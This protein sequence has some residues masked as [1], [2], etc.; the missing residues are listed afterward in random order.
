VGGFLRICLTLDLSMV[1]GCWCCHQVALAA[2]GV[3]VH[4]PMLPPAVQQ[5]SAFPIPRAALQV[6]T[7]RG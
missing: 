1:C 2:N 3:V 7:P 5:R 4:P 6:H